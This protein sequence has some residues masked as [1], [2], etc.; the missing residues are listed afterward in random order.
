MIVLFGFLLGFFASV[1]LGPVN[2]I[3]VSQVLRR[4]FLYG[5]L[6]GATSGLLDTLYCL[7][8]TFGFS[9]IDFRYTSWLPLLKIIAAG[10]LIFF[11]LRLI[12]H[13]RKPNAIVRSSS[14][15]VHRPIFSAFFLYISNPSIYA[16]WLT[17]AGYVN[18]HDLIPHDQ[19]Q[20]IVF[21]S[22]AG[23]G[24]LAW[25]LLLSYNVAKYHHQFNE[26]IM[27]RIFIGIAISLL[28]FALYALLTLFI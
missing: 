24:T 11:S 23:I 28:L 8:F 10:I 4:G 5:A 7:V 6:V 20:Q 18:T 15:E 9:R 27:R 16:F 12:A 14:M 25:Y 1:P 3:A 13:A 26:K 19:R 2:L 21:A 17:V 22:S